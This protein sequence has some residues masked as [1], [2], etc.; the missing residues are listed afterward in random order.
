MDRKKALT[1]GMILISIL[2]LVLVTTPFIGSLRPNARGAAALPRIDISHIKPG[3]FE[4]VPHP[5]YGAYFNGYDW[6]LFIYRAVDGHFLFWDVPTK[7]GAVGMPDL[8]WWRP[9]HQCHNFGPT[10]VDDS[11]DEAQPITCHDSEL[12]SQWWADQWKW[13]INGKAIGSMVDDMQSTRGSV[14][15]K[16]FVFAKNS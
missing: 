6:S 7:D 10:F 14:K 8:R 9:F 13:D 11:V 12:P 2:G 5:G 3:T 16:Y 4:L 15:G 1:I